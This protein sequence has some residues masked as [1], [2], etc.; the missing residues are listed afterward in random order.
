MSEPDAKPKARTFTGFLRDVERVVR[1]D[2]AISSSAYRIL[3]AILA[4]LNEKSGQY[5]VKDEVLAV[6]CGLKQRQS[7]WE[8]RTKLKAAGVLG[9][10]A[11]SLE[12][13]KATTYWLLISGQDV[14][15]R[16]ALLG[17]AKRE[18]R[19]RAKSDEPRRTNVRERLRSKRSAVADERKESLT[20]EAPA[21]LTNAYVGTLTNA[22][23]LHPQPFTP[24]DSATDAGLDSGRT[25]GPFNVPDGNLE[26]LP[27]G[28]DV[29][30]VLPSPSPSSSP[31]ARP[32]PALVDDEDDTPPAV[33]VLRDDVDDTAPAAPAAAK[34]APAGDR[35]PFKEW[36]ML[37][38]GGA[39]ASWV[40]GDRPSWRT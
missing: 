35:L 6:D 23:T 10:K 38:L 33:P 2:A 19:E 29:A 40:S 26:A 14:D 5:F 39:T 20:Q 11:G 31:P 7:L 8:A 9:F 12:G 25:R 1:A 18:A 37:E 13:K 3:A 24:S 15:D 28:T 27:A 22:Y 34:S 4:G 21:T 16:L 32:V 30:P 17:D 36:V